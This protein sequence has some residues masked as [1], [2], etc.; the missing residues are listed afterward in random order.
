ME[1][2]CGTQIRWLSR[3]T[4]FVPVSSEAALNNSSILGWP[5]VWLFITF[6]L[7][8]WGIRGTGIPWQSTFLHGQRNSTYHLQVRPSLSSQREDRTRHS[9]V[10]YARCTCVE[11]KSAFSFIKRFP[12]SEAGRQVSTLFA[13]TQLIIYETYTLQRKS[14]SPKLEHFQWLTNPFGRSR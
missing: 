3:G 1:L 8:L 6:Y 2:Y 14:I 9:F 7:T 12:L 10:K 4:L 11:E 5:T 13:W